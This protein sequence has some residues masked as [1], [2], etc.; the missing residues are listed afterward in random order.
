LNKY[1]YEAVIGKGGLMVNLQFIS[2]INREIERDRERERIRIIKKSLKT[3][4][5]Q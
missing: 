2:T 1:H 3:R 4:M 5:I